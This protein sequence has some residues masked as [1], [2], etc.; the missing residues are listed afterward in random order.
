[1]KIKALVFATA[2]LVAGVANAQETYVTNSFDS[3]LYVGLSA[4]ANA[5]FDGL[6]GALKGGNLV[7]G[8]GVSLELSLGK[9]ITPEFGFRANLTGINAECRSGWFFGEN[10]YYSA[11]LAFLWDAT[12]TFGGLNPQRVVSVV[13]YLSAG[14]YKSVGRGAGF[15]AGVMVPV[16][17]SEKWSIVPDVR[18]VGFSDAILV[19]EG[20]GVCANVQVTLGAQ[21]KFGKKTS[22]ETAAAVTAPLVVAAAEAEAAKAE[23]EAAKEQAQVEIKDLSEDLAK[24]QKENE[25]LRAELDG[26]ASENAAIVKNLMSTPAC[27]F[28]EIGQ[29]TLSVKELEHLDRTVK[30]MIAQGKNITFTVCGYSD[31]N[32]GSARRNNQLAKER[33]NYIVKLLTDKYGLSQDQFVVKHE[34]NTNVYTTIEL[35]RAVLIQAAE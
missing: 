19:G 28:F 6:Y 35:N 7:K 22:F 13:P 25:A 23:V 12:T 11:S 9:W 30:T 34:G 24:L 15:G 18:F 20:A 17:L 3:N 27:V 10:P 16:A 21:Y 29:A 1:M 26:I 31:K 2:I 5:S 32:T 14:Y 4:G 33:A 8:G